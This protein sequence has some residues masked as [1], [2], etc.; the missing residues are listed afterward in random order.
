MEVLTKKRFAEGDVEK[1]PKKKFKPRFNLPVLN[2]YHR[3][4]DQRYWK[5]WPKLTWEG[6][7]GL[8]SQI[9]PEKLKEMAIDTGLLI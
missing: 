2:D 3:K 9:N 8:H 4:A 5:L 6:S 1:P 7:R